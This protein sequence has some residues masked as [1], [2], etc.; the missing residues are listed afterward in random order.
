[1]KRKIISTLLCCSVVATIMAGCGEKETKKADSKTSQTTE[2]EAKNEE[3]KDKE[4]DYS[5]RAE[6]SFILGLELDDREVLDEPEDVCLYEDNIKLPITI[7]SLQN[8][9]VNSHEHVG[10]DNTPIKT[11]KFSDALAQD[12]EVKYREE[13]FNLYDPS[14]T[15]VTADIKG[16]LYIGSDDEERTLADSV[17]AGVWHMRDSL[18]GSKSLGMTPEEL[19]EKKK[20]FGLD[21]EELTDDTDRALIYELIDRLGKPNYINFPLNGAEGTIDNILDPEN[22]DYGISVSYCTI[23]WGFENYSINVTFCEMSDVT[24]DGEYRSY[25]HQEASSSME[26][27]YYPKGCSDTFDPEKN[28]LAEFEKYREEKLGK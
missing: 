21:A 26:L 17:N 18:T 22:K 4:V 1:M 6:K 5:K 24:N 3:K 10:G 13:Y 25:L 16:S 15:D 11:Y 9:Q 12:T 19:N 28:Q 20:E 23:G 27:Y 2:T 8:Y 7:E 14:A